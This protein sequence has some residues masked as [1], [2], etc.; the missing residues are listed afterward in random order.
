[1]HSE[2]EIEKAKEINVSLFLERIKFNLEEVAE[3]EGK[4]IKLLGSD[5]DPSFVVNII[6]NKG[7]TTQEKMNIF[8]KEENSGK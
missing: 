2:S 5:V 3:Y 7:L 4:I 1:M 8:F 6:R